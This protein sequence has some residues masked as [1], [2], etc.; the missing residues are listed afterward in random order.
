MSRLAAA[1]RFIS[2][3]GVVACAPV[4]PARFAD[5]D[6]IEEVDDDRPIAVPRKERMSP[7]SYVDAFGRRPA[8]EGM[9][10]QRTPDAL[11][12]NALDEVPTSSWFVHPAGGP[13]GAV[14]NVVNGP[15]V[16]PLLVLSRMPESGRNGLVV[17]DARGLRYELGRD[18]V[19]R[20][21]L[22][23]TAAIVASHL[24]RALGYRTPEVSAV[25]LVEADLRVEAVGDA[26]PPVAA[27]REFL[28]AGP[29]PVKG[30]YRASATRWPMGIDVGPTPPTTRKDDPN[31][32]IAHPDRRTLRAL[33]VVRAW[34]RCPDFGVKSLRDVYVGPPNRGHLE[35]FA[36]GLEGALGADD[37]QGEAEEPRSLRTDANPTAGENPLWLLVSLGLEA[38]KRRGNVRYPLLGDFNEIV[39]DGHYGTIGF[40]PTY[41]A[42]PADAYW[43][44][45]QMVAVSREVIEAAVVSA[46]LPDEAARARLVEVLE[47]RRLAVIARAFAAVTPCEVVRTDGSAVVLRDAGFSPDVARTR[48]E[49]AFLDGDGASL[50]PARVLA[51]GVAVFTI[52]VPRAP[53][54]IL[55]LRAAR[56]AW[57]APRQ[58]EAHFRSNGGALRLVGVRH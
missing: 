56:G 22:R 39:K 5:L 55:R 25:S 20:P 10:F 24:M 46:A 40:E 12:V 41:R 23:T 7:F 21:W 44:A 17:I 47:S 15:P 57:T 42:L 38:R 31:D 53:Y 35:H 33:A 9:I 2:L 52:P 30:H 11:D 16:A 37:A 27:V 6:P 13:L 29:S 50:G 58:F 32:R 3:A 34:L 36:V 45:K 26:P 4:R 48:Y 49:V 19:D 51:P 43:L 54:V 18:P 8:V 1:L 14:T 28:D